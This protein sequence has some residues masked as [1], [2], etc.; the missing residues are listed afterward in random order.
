M[1]QPLLRRFFNSVYLSSSGVSGTVSQRQNGGDSSF[2]RKQNAGQTR[3]EQRIAFDLIFGLLFIVALHG[4]S[5]AKV[6]IILYI[7]YNLA[8]HLKREHVPIATWVFNVG[9][10][11]AN[12][13]CEGYHMAKV[14][15][16]FFSSENTQW[17]ATLDSYGGLMPRWEVLFNFTVL[18]LIS[19]NFDY[20]WSRDQSGSSGLEVSLP[21]D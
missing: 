20:I 6:L 1:I 8:T 17:A 15:E 5:A 11:F 12:E 7:N 3:L 14:A 13:L 10:L 21:P 4:I 9:I 2:G 18:R 19:F 16:V